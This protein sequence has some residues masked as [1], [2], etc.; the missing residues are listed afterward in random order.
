VSVL[1]KE[2]PSW[3]GPIDQTRLQGRELAALSRCEVNVRRAVQSED[4]LV[5][6]PRP[7]IAHLRRRAARHGEESENL[8]KGDSGVELHAGQV[9]RL[10][11]FSSLTVRQRTTRR[12]FDVAAPGTETFFTDRAPQE[13]RARAGSR[14]RRADGTQ[15][16]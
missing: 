7:E 6:R 5:L 9:Q 14:H 10:A 4:I 11:E 3:Q 13:P 1:R 2:E 15:P 16:P 12:R 8:S